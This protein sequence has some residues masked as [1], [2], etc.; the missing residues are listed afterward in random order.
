[1]VAIG[2]DVRI[3]GGVSVAS[4]WGCVGVGRA[5]RVAATSCA[6]RVCTMLTSCVAIGAALSTSQDERSTLMVIR[7]DRTTF[8]AIYTPPHCSPMRQEVIEIARPGVIEESF[9]FGNS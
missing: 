5:V 8:L 1:M 9:S 4:G 7:S 3:K 2:S 6:T